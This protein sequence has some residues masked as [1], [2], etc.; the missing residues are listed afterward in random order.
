MYSTN[1]QTAN[2]EEY[3]VFECNKDNQIEETE[4]LYI[5]T[6]ALQR[7]GYKSTQS[8]I[9]ILPNYF[10]QIIVSSTIKYKLTS[11]SMTSQ[12]TLEI[13][14]C[15]ILQTDV[16]ET[17]LTLVELAS[18]LIDFFYE[19]SVHVNWVASKSTKHCNR[20]TASINTSGRLKDGQTDS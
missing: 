15:N 2:Y 14:A 7:R 13:W 12:T 6:A 4:F 16:A 5:Q 9:W 11:T 10:N 18:N 8:V 20:T 17:I 1:F 3:L 19:A